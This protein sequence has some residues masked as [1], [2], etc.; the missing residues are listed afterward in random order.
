MATAPT[1]A[2][3]YL[4][5]MLRPSRRTLPPSHRRRH[6]PVPAPQPRHAAAGAVPLTSPRRHGKVKLSERDRE[7]YKGNMQDF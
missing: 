6:R 2:G 4:L 5:L 1:A 7:T 3:W